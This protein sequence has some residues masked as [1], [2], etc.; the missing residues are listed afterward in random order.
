MSRSTKRLVKKMFAE[1]DDDLGR[2]LSMRLP[3][4]A[5]AEDLS[6]ETYLR[7]LRV[8]RTDLIRRPEALL[9]RIASNL[10]YEFYL[11]RSHREKT[12]TELVE[13]S[14]SGE[15]PTEARADARRRVAKLEKVTAT[16]AP[17]CRAALIMARR[18]GM[19][20]AEIAKRLGVSTSM[21]KKYLK[22]AHTLCR[23]RMKDEPGEQKQ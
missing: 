3:S 11:K 14:P 12:D 5:D 21:V 6:Q 1:S 17:K 15:R 7:L 4:R 22:Q 9:F 18:D 13:G 16:L 8:E 20:Y 2:F 23:K 19:T 10:I